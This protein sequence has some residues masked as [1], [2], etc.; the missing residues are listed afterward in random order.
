MNMTINGAEDVDAR[1]DGKNNRISVR[2][3]M[4]WELDCVACDCQPV[5]AEYVAVL[6]VTSSEKNMISEEQKVQDNGTSS[7][8]IENLDHF[9]ELQMIRRSDGSVISS[10]VLPLSLPRMQALTQRPCTSDFSLMSSFAIASST[11]S[12]I[13]SYSRSILSA[14]LF[15]L[16]HFDSLFL[17]FF[18]NGFFYYIVDGSM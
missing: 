9:I 6:G 12:W 4:A 2:C 15:L 18:S 3:V 11:S 7:P 13:F 16:C 5:D 8:A 17:K 14:S 1:S 10:D